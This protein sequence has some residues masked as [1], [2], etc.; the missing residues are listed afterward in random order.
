MQ[1]HSRGEGCRGVTATKYHPKKLYRRTT[2]VHLSAQMQ[3]THR[4]ISVNR[5]LFWGN[6]QFLNSNRR[7]GEHEAVKDGL[8]GSEDIMSLA[9]S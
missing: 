1:E 8:N 9:S 6:I 7:V 4:T 3:H 5:N 2:R